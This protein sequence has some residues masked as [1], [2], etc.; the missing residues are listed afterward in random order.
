MLRIPI[1]PTLLVLMFWVFGRLPSSSGSSIGVRPTDSKPYPLAGVSPDPFVAAA[2]L[3]I[4]AVCSD[5]VILVAVHTTFANEPLLS[6]DTVSSSS[7]TSSTNNSTSLQDL[8]KSYRGPFRIYSIDG[9]GTGLICA[10]WRADG[11]ILAEYCRSVA[12]DELAVFGEPR[13]ND[14]YGN[15]LASETSLWMAQCAVSERVRG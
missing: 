8:P 9:F 7:S 2:P 6:D 14:D 4:A 12:S 11:Q 15:Y 1:T 5:G 3:I 10:G 13:Q